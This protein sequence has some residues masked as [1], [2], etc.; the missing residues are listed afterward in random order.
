[1]PD[2]DALIA[3]QLRFGLQSL[4]ARNGVLI[5]SFGAADEDEI[6]VYYGI[7]ESDTPDI[8]LIA[9]ARE[10]NATYSVYVGS[11]TAAL[12]ADIA[13]GNPSGAIT[14]KAGSVTRVILEVK[15]TRTVRY[16]LYLNYAE[17]PAIDTDHDGL[18]DLNYLEDVHAISFNFAGGEIGYRSSE[19][20][21]LSQ[22][23]CPGGVCRGYELQR[24]LDFNDPASYRDA[25]ANQAQWSNAGWQPIAMEGALF[26][27]NGN[28]ISNLKVRSSGGGG[29]FSTLASS[30]IESLGLLNVDLSGAS[31]SGGIARTLSAGG[32][33]SNSYVIGSIE[34]DTQRR[35]LSSREYYRQ[36]NKQQLFHRHYSHNRWCSWERYRRIDSLPGWHPEHQEQPCNRQVDS[37][38]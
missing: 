27:G 26:D 9:T 19:T 12:H 17:R 32:T 16:T 10:A 34:T 2:C 30:S 4:I 25:D 38:Q 21:V 35:R 6:G 31:V 3:P 15:G 33:I 18:V 24:S 5:P 29:L 23:G 20:A 36:R 22:A 37:E 1:M 13:S 11:G 8:E 7:A 28:T 14:L